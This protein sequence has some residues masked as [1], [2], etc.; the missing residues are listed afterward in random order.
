[1][2]GVKE[3][4][5]PSKTECGSAPRSQRVHAADARDYGLHPKCL[6]TGRWSRSLD[7]GVA[8]KE[9]EFKYINAI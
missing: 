9:I 5:L 6:D 7:A 2:N 3:R 1:M 8:S 4:S